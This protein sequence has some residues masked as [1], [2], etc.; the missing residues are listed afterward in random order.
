[1]ISIRNKLLIYAILIAVIPTAVLGS[2]YYSYA[3]KNTKNNVNQASMETFIQIDKNLSLKTNR[4]QYASDLIF[5]SKR[6]QELLRETNFSENTDNTAKAIDDLDETFA[7][8]YEVE[9]ELLGIV[10]FPSSGGKYLSRCTV[11]D[12]RV[13]N[14]AMKYGNVDENSGK[15]MWMGS[16]DEKPFTGGDGQIAMVG[17]KIK[18]TA[19]MKDGKL[20]ATVYILLENTYLDQSDANIS[21]GSLAIYDEKAKLIMSSGQH[22]I[23]NIWTVSLDAGR[24]IFL[25]SEGEFVEKIEG[26]TYEIVY[27]TSPHTGWKYVKTFVYDEYF[28]EIIFIRQ[29]T[30]YCIV[31]LLA[32]IL[33]VN[34]IFV[35][36]IT[37]PIDEI[38]SAMK[39]VGKKNF[40]VSMNIHSKDEFGAISHGFNVMV[41][42]VNE[43]FSQV[44]EQERRRKEADIMSLQYQM[45]PHFLYNTLGS[46]RLISLL[47]GDEEVSEML[48]V[49]GDFLRSAINNAGKLI[50]VAEELQNIKNYIY[51]YQIRYGNKLDVAFDADESLLNNRMPTMIIQPVVENAIIH[52]LNPKLEAD[53][54]ARL[55]ISVRDCGDKLQ[56]A[57]WDNGI[58]ISQEKLV[59]LAEGN[60]ESKE[61]CHIGIA[62]IKQRIA[63]MFGDDYGM[64]V[65][66]EKGSFTEIV[67]NLPKMF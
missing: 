44:V 66:S 21:I 37:A 18:D 50:T 28:K 26:E 15:V 10:M 20:L 24:K 11:D 4:L 22:I 7:Q 31:L 36:R 3:I 55:R 17:C 58:G 2:F 61:R 39:E 14:F 25:N 32:V 43:L 12:E 65:R 52:G 67:I 33:F 41:M 64:E 47:K 46:I 5:T 13:V 49:M 42:E 35:K 1:M 56:F 8:F 27:Y 57:V 29:T 63:D 16:F 60:M 40:D 53:S 38:V 62:N 54:G 23:G 34:Y 19:Y 48:Y 9:Q 6:V 45:T 51:L 59:Q 30:L